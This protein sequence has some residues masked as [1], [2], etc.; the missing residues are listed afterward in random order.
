MGVVV[1]AAFLLLMVAFRSL[2]IPLTASIMNIL[3]ALASFGVI[4][5]VFQEGHLGSIFAVGRP[6]PIDAF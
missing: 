2:V 4:V 6:G 1:L 3:A 5:F